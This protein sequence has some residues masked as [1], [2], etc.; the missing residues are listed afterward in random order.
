MELVHCEGSTAM[1]QQVCEAKI[2]EQVAFRISLLKKILPIPARSAP[3]P[4]MY[5]QNEF[6]KVA[7]LSMPYTVFVFTSCITQ[8]FKVTIAITSFVFQIYAPSF[9][10]YSYDTCSHPWFVSLCNFTAFDNGM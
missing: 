4:F 3:Q 10:Y 7:P 6:L 1:F 8:A 2:V 9:P 5:C